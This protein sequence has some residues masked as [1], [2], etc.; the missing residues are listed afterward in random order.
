M[1]SSRGTR[2]FFRGPWWRSASPA[3]VSGVDVMWIEG[4]IIPGDGELT[5]KRI[6]ARG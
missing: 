4:G 2:A 5:I 3:E 1:R 6:K